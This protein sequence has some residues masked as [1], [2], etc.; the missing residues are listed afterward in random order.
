MSEPYTPDTVPHPGEILSE[1][2]LF[3]DWSQQRLYFH[4]KLTREQITDLCA[5]KAPITAAIAEELGRVL[6]RPAHFW[7]NLQ[8]VYDENRKVSG[9]Q[10]EL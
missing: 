6:T 2:M 10:A 4:T 7:L 3:N 9:S 8:K 1:Y 5:G